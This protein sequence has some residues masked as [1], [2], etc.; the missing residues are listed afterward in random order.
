VLRI[1]ASPGGLPRAAHEFAVQ[2]VLHRRDFPAPRP[3]L[4]ECGTG[5][6]GGPFLL[7][8]RAP[9]RPL[10]KL[11]ESRPWRLWVLPRRMGRLHA[12]LHGLSA[13][14]VP[15]SAGPFLARRLEELDG[16]IREFGLAGLRPGF[17][18]L[19]QH[20]PRGRAG[21]HPLHLDWHPLNLM[22][23]EDGRVTALDWAEA[24]VGDRHADVATT[25]L[26]LRCAPAPV[27]GAWRRL[28]LPLARGVTSRQY[29]R[30]YRKLMPVDGQRLSY[31]CAWAALERL[32]R[33]GRWLAAG[34]ESTGAKP[35]A[36]CH[37]RPTHLGDVARFFRRHTGVDIRL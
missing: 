22:L 24:D 20:R 10:L 1:Y 35:S 21:R 9:G 3:V 16:V 23:A 12:R 34:P 13:E 11:L 36:F 27:R 14:G 28:A 7:M 29:L 33:Y 30:A 4:L 25:L 8:E 6:F 37:V 31:Y 5:V 26:L 19:T 17:S 15:A 18:W 32:A 2:E